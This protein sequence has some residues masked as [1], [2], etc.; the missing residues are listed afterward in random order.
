M[1]RE[2][3]STSFT[4]PLLVWLSP[5]LLSLLLSAARIPL[6]AHPPR[7]I[8]SLALA[9]LAVVQIV[10][11]AMLAP[12]LFRTLAGIVA[13]ILTAAPMLQLAEFLSSSSINETAAQYLLLA[14]WL[15]ALSLIC[16]S[17]RERDRAWLTAIAT[18]WSLGGVLVAYLHA[19]FAP[20]RSSSDI[21]F[22]PAF[23]AL[24][25]SQ[26]RFAPH[27]WM[28]VA[29]IPA[30]ALVIAFAAHRVHRS[31]PPEKGSVERNGIPPEA[32]GA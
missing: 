13:I 28:T 12:M 6:S 17:L 18:T 26:H 2:K 10:A 22:G 15:V 11:A 29:T 20:A 9:Q 16:L 31:I 21:L 24:R 27:A 4:L 5:Q 1:L 8:E 3:T 32:R 23:L 25:N 14:N 7:S 30:L 19:E